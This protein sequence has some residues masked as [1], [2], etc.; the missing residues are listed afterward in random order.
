MRM[1]FAHV[2]IFLSF[3]QGVGGY[4]VA[5][6]DYSCSLGF[7]QLITPKSKEVI[8]ARGL[9]LNDLILSFILLLRTNI[10]SKTFLFSLW[11]VLILCDFLNLDCLRIIETSQQ[12]YATAFRFSY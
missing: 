2:V 5:F 1:T 9:K 8:V 3:M 6:F 12:P 7:K 4:L 11:K 10:S